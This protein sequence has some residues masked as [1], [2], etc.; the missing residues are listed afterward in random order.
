MNPD[1]KF[2]SPLL[3]TTQKLLR[4]LDSAANQSL[5][6]YRQSITALERR[7]SDVIMPAWRLI[8]L[9]PSVGR[10]PDLAH[11]AAQLQDFASD[12]HLLATQIEARPHAAQS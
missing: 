5:D 3:E 9:A 10:E 12:A 6:P 7:L 11:F 4:F 8:Q 2:L 1:L